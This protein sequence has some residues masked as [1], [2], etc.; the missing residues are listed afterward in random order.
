MKH[1]FLT[2]ATGFIG[3]HL[4][5]FLIERE[6]K[7]TAL[8]RDNSRLKGLPVNVVAGDV[9]RPDSIRIPSDVDS[10]FH[11]AGLTKARRRKEYFEVNET[12]TRNV[13]S[14]VQRDTP[15]AHFVYMSSLAAIGP[16]SSLSEP[17]REDAK[18]HPVSS[19][20]ASKLAGEKVL[21]ASNLSFTIVRPPAV[22]GE[23]E[24]D[25]FTFIQMANRGFSLFPGFSE[26]W[27]SLVYG[28][29]LCR[30]VIDLAEKFRGERSTFF[31]AYPDFFSWTEFR[32]AVAAALGRRVR[33]IRIPRFF[34]Y[35]IAFVQEVQSF[36]TGKPALLNFEK[37]REIVEPFWTCDVSAMQSA[38]GHPQTP[39]PLA[40]E[41]TVKWYRNNNWL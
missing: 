11:L 13:I 4:A 6:I 35:P 14:A 15:G 19:Y 41:Q 37:C 23:G 7:V 5:I 27:F 22:F 30:L 24:R 16:S 26:S 9:T 1:V 39:F 17:V 18:P 40:L 3:H 29:D 31:V 32:H 36:F 38:G 2:G 8:V 21:K 20:G 12:G 34:I 25:I 28:P 10:V 33:L